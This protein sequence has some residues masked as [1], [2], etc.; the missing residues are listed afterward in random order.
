MSRSRRI[1]L[2]LPLVTFVAFLPVLHFAFI[3]FDD[4]FYVTAN[5]QVS[6]GIS[7]AGVKWAFT[8]L[9]QNNWHP[10]T[11]LSHM[12]DCTLFGLNPAGHH[13]VNVLFHTANTVL[14][15]VLLL[16]L[17]GDLWPAAFVAALFAWHPLHVESVAWIAERK[18]VLSTFFAMLALIC[19]AKFAQKKCRRSFWLAVLF[20]ALGLLSKPMLVTLP[21]VLLLLDYWPL[22]R[23][24]Q[25]EGGPCRLV[26]S[27]LIYEKW[28][29]FLLT[30]LSC[31]ITYLAQS[32]KVEGNAAVASLKSLPLHY[33]L[34]QIPVNYVEYL[35]KLTWPAKLAV[36]Y[37]LAE[38]IPVV[39]T[40]IALAVLLFLSVLV[41]RWHR[42]H[43]YLLVGWLWF[44]GM[45]VPVIGLVQIGGAALADRYTYVP[46]IGIFIISA[47]AARDVIRQFPATTKLFTFAAVII[48]ACCLLDMERQLAFW[49]NSERLFRHT[50]AVTKDNEF[51]CNNLANA[52]QADGKFEE[53]VVEYQTS[54]KLNPARPLLHSNLGVTL[55][56]MGRHAEA[57]AEFREASRLSPGDTS[58][59][60]RAASEFIEL[61]RFDE[62]LKELVTAE[63][64][65]PEYSPA[66]FGAARAYFKLGRDAEAVDELRTAVRLAP[67]D[68]QLLARTAYYL[69]ANENAAARDGKIALVLAAN[70]NI[71]SGRNQPM[72]F[73]ILGMAYAEVGDFTAAQ[74]AAQTALDLS[75][76][77]RMK[78]TGHIRQRLE[79]YKQHKPWRESFRATNAPSKN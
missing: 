47:F 3:N 71:L 39:Q 19:Y 16:R 38:T 50:L 40:M 1:A 33:R 78:G 62:A 64:L 37:P 77:L 17:T 59:H 48:L 57:L 29:F 56:E 51:I 53:A 18:D 22:R 61:G 30:I 13:C 63:K 49:K 21:F 6:N 55:D 12:A 26:S 68:Y 42:S 69:A 75:T 43:P 73:D 76:M 70:A 44:L 32:K 34:E 41:W 4:D 28:P 45:L 74:T 31:A 2:L 24:F 25:P 46:S 35:A 9:H 72:I 5:Q 14:L 15:F 67:D 11:W 23:I 60:C 66:H 58:F 20:F 52:L 54:I 79:L 65:S 36:F 8:T 10:L 7:W 27:R